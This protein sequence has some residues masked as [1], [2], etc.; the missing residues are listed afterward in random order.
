MACFFHLFIYLPLTELTQLFYD[1]VRV[2]IFQQHILEV[3]T[4][5]YMFL[6]RFFLFY[7]KF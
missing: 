2:V 4:T 6:F 1:P 5:C 7:I 3:A